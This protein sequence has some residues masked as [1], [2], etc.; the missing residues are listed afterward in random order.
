MKEKGL[1][2]IAIKSFA[3]NYQRYI[4]G[5]VIYS[6]KDLFDS[7][8]ELVNSD[9]LTK[10]DDSKIKQ[11]AVLKLNG[12][13]GTTMGLTKAKTLLEIKPD[14]TFLDVIAKQTEFSNMPLVLM[15]SYNTSKDTMQYLA[16]YPD[17]NVKEIVQSQIPKISEVNGR[18]VEYPKNPD[19]EWCPPGHGDLYSTIFAD[20]VLDELLDEGINYLFV[21]NSDNLG[22]TFSPEIAT[23]FAENNFD[24]L[25]EVTKK[26]EKDLKGGCLAKMNGKYELMELSQ[27]PQDKLD[28]ILDIKKYPYFNTNCLWINLK[29][30]KKI[31]DEQGGVVNLPLIINHKT[32]DPTDKASEKVIQLET[33]MGCSFRIFE[34]VSAIE[35]PRSRFFPVK[36]NDDLA[37]LRSP[38]VTITE[39]GKLILSQK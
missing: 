23:Y 34:N 22:A 21:A 25:M 32:V 18:P 8:G 33:G 1:G 3:N 26:T 37:Y 14:V 15:N 12:G 16:A 38:A 9:G 2:E 28:D 29:S 13:L 10:S 27:V 7:V 11:F 36:T 24:F 31:L 4:D 39:D 35:V 5:E 30:L 17:L 20:G 6:S 19:L